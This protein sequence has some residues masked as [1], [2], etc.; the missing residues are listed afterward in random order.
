MGTTDG[1]TVIVVGGAGAMGRYAA[2]SIARLGSA[3]RL[4][5][6]D[7]NVEYAE[8][9]AMEIGGRC[10]ALE[11]DATDQDALRA[12]FSSCDVV[13]STLGPFAV[14]GGPVLR[15]ALESG[16]NYLDIDDD[17]QST[18]EALEMHDVAL[19]KGLT[20]VI[21]L[22][23]SPGFSNML[24]ML[25]AERLDEVDTLY[26]GWNLSAAV[27]EE[28]PDYPAP[29][30]APAA[31]EHWLLQC[32]G[33]IRVWDD[34]RYVDVNPVQKVL[35][36]LPAFGEHTAYTMGHP[37][38]ITLPQA[39]RGLRRSRNLQVGPEWL[40]EHLRSVAADFDAGR[41][42]LSDGAKELQRA[43]KPS[44][45]PD[46]PKPRRLPYNW[47]LAEGSKDGRAHTVMTF[48]NGEP[49]GRMGGHS[50]VPVAI[51]VEL[52]RHGRLRGKGTLSPEAAVDPHAFL[53]MYA[54]FLEPPL[55]AGESAISRIE[56]APCE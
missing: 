50:G 2:R 12:A 19:S 39:I 53:D 51:G 41:V 52:L 45:K 17:W 32:A 31:V 13:C 49:R 14:F 8:R 46:G 11:L 23:S 54:R 27:T 55:A 16:C 47:A 30:A 33:K 38:P 4:L 37:E 24:A 42:S 44:R 3:G 28:E 43:P 9:L 20:A 7:R 48:P 21:G 35:L 15:A 29:E 5:I 56:S 25:A 40:M 36:N 26:T 18:V 34:G 1:W 6:A 10:E 22:G